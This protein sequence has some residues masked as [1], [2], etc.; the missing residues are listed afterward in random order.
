V[1]NPTKTI[2]SIAEE[3]INLNTN[4]VITANYS[5]Y[6][7]HIVV[8]GQKQYL[9]KKFPRT[10]FPKRNDN[11]LITKTKTTAVAKMKQE[12]SRGNI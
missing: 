9:W 5:I 6:S 12:K 8:F 7:A 3:P 10:T 4:Q 2:Q 1:Y 11:E